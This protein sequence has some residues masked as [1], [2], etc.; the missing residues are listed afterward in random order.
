MSRIMKED[1]E[2]R[3]LARELAKSIKT[4]KGLSDFSRQLKK[5]TADLA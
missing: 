4:E 3:A 1:E 2:M 5:M